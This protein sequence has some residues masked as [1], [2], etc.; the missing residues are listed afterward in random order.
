MQHKLIIHNSHL[1]PAW[2][3]FLS[4]KQPDLC[5]LWRSAGGRGDLQPCQHFLQLTD[6][7]SS[8]APSAERP[9]PVKVGWGLSR[10]ETQGWLKLRHI[11]PCGAHPKL[12][13]LGNV[14]AACSS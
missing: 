2:L 14:T 1:F 10:E 5:Q 9:I 6:Y 4:L 12:Q 13:L 8:T 3:S 7:G 11:Q